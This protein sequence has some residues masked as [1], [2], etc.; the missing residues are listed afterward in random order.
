MARI[1]SN[2]EDNEVETEKTVSPNFQPLLEEHKNG[3]HIS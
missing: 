3:K 1:F 2:A